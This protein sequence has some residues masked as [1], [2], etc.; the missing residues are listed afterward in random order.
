[1]THAYTRTYT[2]TNTHAH[3]RTYAYEY[4]LLIACDFEVDLC[5]M[6]QSKTDQFDWIQKSGRTPSSAT[7][8]SGD[9]IEERGKYIYIEASGRR[10][11]GKA[12]MLSTPLAT[13]SGEKQ[14]LEFFYHMY[15]A[16]MGSLVVSEEDNAGNK[17]DLLTLSGN[18]GDRWKQ[19]LI[20][21]NGSRGEQ[22]RV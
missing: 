2:R 17:K 12:A 16:N 10:R 5:G 20:E 9:R 15:G 21:L 6:E 4:F 3:I 8:P 18:K 11:R 1:M 13:L 7:G 22:K 19:Q 14:C